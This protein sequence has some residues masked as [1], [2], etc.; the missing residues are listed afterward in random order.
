MAAD[1]VPAR[2][3]TSST[4]GSRSM[5]ASGARPGFVLTVRRPVLIWTSEL[6]LRRGHRI[7]AARLSA[8]LSPMAQD[9]LTRRAVIGGLSGTLAVAAGALGRGPRRSRSAGV[10]TPACLWPA[11]LGSRALWSALARGC[12]G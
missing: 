2:H 1:G 8:I 7:V 5:S 3:R 4:S 9:G 11:G 10:T 12:I 6:R